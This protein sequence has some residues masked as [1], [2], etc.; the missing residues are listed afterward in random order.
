MNKNQVKGAVK[1]IAGKVQQ[2]AGRLVG[3]K[4]QEAK[5][6]V[7]QVQG[8]AKRNLGDAQEVMKDSLK[9]H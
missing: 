7:K 3:S 5:G 4:E 6:L 9:K 8:K 1:D 2:K